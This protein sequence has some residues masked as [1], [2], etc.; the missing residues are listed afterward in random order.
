MPKSN[1][2]ITYHDD[3]EQGSQEWLKQRDK[4]FTG[5]NAYK[6]LS[7]FGAGDWAM[8]E[9]VVWSGNYHTKRGH[10]LEPEC[11]ELYSA[12]KGIECQ[13][14]GFVT[15]SRYPNCLYSPDAYTHDR[16]IEVKCFS[17]KVHLKEIESPSV[18]V[19][20]QCHF[21][22][23]ILEKNRTDLIF[24]CPKPSTWNDETD[25]QFPVPIE[26]MLV[27]I[28]IKKDKKIQDNFKNIIDSYNAKYFK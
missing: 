7:S 12:I 23:M 13:H 18:K 2:R 19:L 26:K 27:I 1:S 17:P 22:Q 11:I 24:Y 3:V 14:T 21:G 25:G 6:L 28:P 10:I 15:N 4:K 5:S 8:N 20:S 16:V 9:S